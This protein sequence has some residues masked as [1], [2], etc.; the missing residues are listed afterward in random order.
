M[1]VDY[2]ERSQ[3]RL[4]PDV[5]KELNIRREN[6]PSDMSLAKFAN[7]MLRCALYDYPPDPSKPIPAKR[8]PK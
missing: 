3:V 5:E 4:A 8:Q 7:Y 1:T 6:H 2:N